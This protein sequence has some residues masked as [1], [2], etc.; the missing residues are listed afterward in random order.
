MCVKERLVRASLFLRKVFFKRSDV[1]IRQGCRLLLCLCIGLVPL[2]SQGAKREVAAVVVPDVPLLPESVLQTRLVS[3]PDGAQLILASKPDQP[4]A[5]LKHALSRLGISVTGEG[6]DDQPF[7][8]GWIRWIYDPKSSRGGSRG[9][10]SFFSRL[11]ERHR[12]RFIVSTRSTGSVIQIEDA[13]HQREVDITPDSTYSWLKWKEYEAQPGAALTFLR[14]LQGDIESAMSS[15]VLSP[16][17]EAADIDVPAVPPV[18]ESPSSPEHQAPARVPDERGST[19]RRYAPAAPVIPVAP[20]A[21]APKLAPATAP[22]A[23]TPKPL[24][25]KTLTPAP[26]SPATHSGALFVRADIE[27]TWRSLLGALSALG[28]SINSADPQQHL[29]STDWIEANYSKKNHQLHLQ[30]TD[31]GDWAFSF[32][33]HGKQRHQFQLMV[34]PAAGGSLVYAYHTGFQEQYDKTPDSSQTL[35]DWRDRRTDPQV[36]M[37]F[38][39][40]LRLLP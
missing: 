8:T 27:R 5:L 3:T 37:A 25:H 4:R 17:G 30:S 31:E 2:T 35:L 1:E 40:R 13:V 23:G 32:T 10:G 29:I 15:R 39:R 21:T 6:R 11:N 38:I 9:H 36:A 28:V 14:R 12:F 20:P 33:G 24:R 16:Q 7:L 18:V 34:V 22:P 19:A 26:D